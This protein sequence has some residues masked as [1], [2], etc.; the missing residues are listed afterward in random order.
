[1]TKKEFDQRLYKFAKEIVRISDEYSVGNSSQVIARQ[2]IRS[3]TSVTA[4]I[5]ESNGASTKKDYINFYSHSLK[6]AHETVFW[7]SLSKDTRKLS[8]RDAD[9]IIREAKEIASIIAA[10][11]KTMRKN[12]K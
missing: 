12:I 7:L 10:S 4:N 11:I 8:A 3:G 6:S 5:I 2:L 1:M 9:P